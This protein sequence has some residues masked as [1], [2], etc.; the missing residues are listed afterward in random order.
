MVVLT[1][2]ESRAISNGNMLTMTFEDASG[3]VRAV[4]FGEA[5]DKWEKKLEA[6]QTYRLHNVPVQRNQ[7]TDAPEL[8]L[9]ADTKIEVQPALALVKTYGTVEE[10]V[11]STAA[12][13]RV[14][15]V[16]VEVG[17]LTQSSRGDA[18]RKVEV[19]DATGELK[20]YLF[21]SH[22]DAADEQAIGTIYEIEGKLSNSNVLVDEWKAVA[23]DELAA[24][25]TLESSFKRRKLDV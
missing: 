18:M 15:A 13:V 1:H 16:L 3:S 10:A 20:L 14:V 19:A 5:H 12:R 24:W 6:G 23:H 9:W 8:K 7:R 21:K 11:Q 4:A 2:R 25:W 22:A 17:E